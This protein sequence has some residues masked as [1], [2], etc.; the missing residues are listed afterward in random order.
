MATS[1][2]VSGYCFG[3]FTLDLR[4]GELIRN[5]RRVHL[6]EK[7]CSL[8]LALAQR[9]GEMITRSELH[10]R[11]WPEDT[12]VDF[13]DGLNTA[14]RKLR[15]ALGDDIQSP[16]YIETVRGRG[17][18][19]LAPV[20]ATV[21]TEESAED[22]PAEA[23]KSA[24][25]VSMPGQVGEATPQIRANSRRLR[26]SVAALVGCLV[27]TAGIASIQHWR[28]AH[29][30]RI[31]VAV[32]P[33]AN[34]TGDPS[35]DYVCNGITEELIARF[36]HLAPKHLR[37]IAPGS[38]EMYAHS[39]EPAQQIARELNVR[40]LIEGSLQQQGANIRVAAQ[41]VRARDQSRLWANVYDGD[42]SNQ[43]EFESSVAEAVAHALSLR[44]P[45]LSQAEYKPAKY[46]AHDAYLK[47]LY[48]LSQRSKS[49]FENAIES[50]GEAV[51]IDPK[52]AAAYAQLAVTYNLMGQYNWMS[53]G[54]ARSQ[55]WG[56]AK[57]A[58][59]VDPGQAEAHAALGLSLWFYRWNLAGAENEF[60]KA[61]ALDPDN[62]DA[63]HWY[64][65][66]LMTSG[67]FS[68]AEEQMQAALE[69]DPRSPI[70]RTN[71]GW[72]Y[73][74]E[75]KNS[76]A[77]AQLQSVVKENPDFLTAHYKLWY[78]YSSEGDRARA[79]E[80]FQW[81]IRSITDPE[82]EGK[83]EDAYAAGGYAAALESLA[84][85]DDPKYYGSR[86]DA[87]RCMVFAGDRGG[88]LRDLE[89]A[90]EVHEGWLIYAPQDPAFASLRT[91]ARFQS[92]VASVRTSSGG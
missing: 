51:A 15:E 74:F 30:R 66:M 57:Q 2:P 82:H 40:Y 29:A 54:N 28:T 72:L 56:A 36:A 38:A 45:A 63:H 6:Q 8:L 61:I 26:L 43:F 9:P 49:G 22:H 89:S 1:P 50:F 11:L 62:V 68:E 80:E 39:S 48:D 58:L 3:P 76:S 20:E 86:V 87:A 81:V 14:M 7:P 4:S 77:V 78:V 5:G 71:L 18:R 44:I 85:S 47:G 52:Y 27:A 35:R 84:G 59:S 21:L 31:S 25:S 83:I 32:L 17:Y 53:P 70:L 33:F 91:D 73:F 90:Y 24:G 64:S 41:L 34:M 23:E 69:T 67:R 12:F 10:A 75:G 60:R 92:I 55:G 37:V 13:E 88:A 19:F 46:E 79:W 16:R 65:Q 42:L